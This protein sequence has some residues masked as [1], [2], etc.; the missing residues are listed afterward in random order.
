MTV[1]PG[2]T[3]PHSLVTIECLWAGVIM[4]DVTYQ[5]TCHTENG[6]ATPIHF[7]SVRTLTIWLKEE[8]PY[9]LSDTIYSLTCKPPGSSNI[10]PTGGGG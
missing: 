5:V 10:L 6:N 3:N 8:L 4:S 1:K 9:I 2:P 7:R